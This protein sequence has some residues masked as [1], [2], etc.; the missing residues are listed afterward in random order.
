MEVVSIVLFWL[1]VLCSVSLGFVSLTQ[2]GEDKR[3]VVA[4]PFLLFFASLV[5]H[6]INS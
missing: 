6:Y 1:G 3:G 2:N 5:A 4:F